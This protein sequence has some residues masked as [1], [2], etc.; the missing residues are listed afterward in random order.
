[1]VQTI[2]AADVTLEDL[3]EK[4]GLRLVRDS[5]FSPEWMSG[6]EQITDAEKATLDR[7]Q[8]NFLTLLKR[9]PILG[10]SVKMVVLSPLLDLAGFYQ[11]PYR[12][13]TETS[14]EVEMKDEE[15][16]FRGRIDVLVL[17]VRVWILVIEAKH[18]NFD[19]QVAVPQ[20]LAYMLGSP[21]VQ[22]PSFGF[23]TNGHTFIFLKLI[24]QPTPQYANSR[25]FSLINPG[26]EINPGMSYMKCW[27]F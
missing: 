17:N 6:T 19:I 23:L 3:E 12:I 15:I 26:N 20:S 18:A 25:L 13:E 2:Q 24:R 8:A 11:H 7:V 1:M 22:L 9:P 4:F 14:I 21:E 10:N 27:E 5:H 16:V